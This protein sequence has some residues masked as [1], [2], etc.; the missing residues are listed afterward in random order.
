MIRFRRSSNSPRYFVPA[1]RAPMS[2]VRRRLLEQGLRNVTSDDPLRQPF[3]NGGLADARIADQGRVVLRPAAQNLNDALN[4][5]RAADHGVELA[6]PGSRGEVDAHLVNGRGFGTLPAFRSG[7]AAGLVHHLDDLRAD[8]LQV[9]RRGSPGRR[10]RCPR[11]RGPSRAG[12]A[13]CRC[14]C[15]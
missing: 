10:R 3:G 12:G 11:P 2:R 9:K 5:L 8:L 7:A 4:L 1:T 13:R 15:D 6:L 14:S